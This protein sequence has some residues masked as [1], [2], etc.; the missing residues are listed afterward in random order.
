MS[1][2]AENST[3]SSKRSA[4]IVS[5]ALTVGLYAAAGAQAGKT[6]AEGVYSREQATRGKASYIERCAACHGR[7]LSGDG[8]APAL[9]TDAF[10]LAWA[11]QKVDSLFS[12]IKATMPADKPGSLSGEATTD[13]VAYIFEFNQLPAGTQPLSIDPAALA[14]ITIAKP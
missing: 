1:G 12:V 2:P 13:I 7:D 9:A 4:A 10:F 11:G 3:K 5:I 8:F 6:T 14:Q